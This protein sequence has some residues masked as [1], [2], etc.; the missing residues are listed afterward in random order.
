MLYLKYCQENKNIYITALVLLHATV[1][2]L[3]Q[4]MFINNYYYFSMYLA[5]TIGRCCLWWISYFYCFFWPIKFQ[6]S[7]RTFI[8][9]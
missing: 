8:S 2:P 6:H 9:I 7:L 4:G 5:I 1:P 3:C